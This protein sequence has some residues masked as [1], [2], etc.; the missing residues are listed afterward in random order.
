M[1]QYHLGIKLQRVQR[2]VQENRLPRALQGQLH[3][4]AGCVFWGGG[5]SADQGM[6]SSLCDRQAPLL[7]ASYGRSDGEF[8]GVGGSADQGKSSC[9]R[10]H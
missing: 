3:V 1:V 5:G 6:S 7:S 8:W 9:V 10:D 4:S 2:F